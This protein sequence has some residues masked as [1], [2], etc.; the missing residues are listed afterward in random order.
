MTYGSSNSFKNDDMSNLSDAEIPGSLPPAQRQ[1]KPDDLAG[2]EISPSGL[3]LHFPQLD[4][5][6]YLPSLLEGFLGSRQWMASEMGKSEGQG[7][8]VAKAAAARDNGKLGERPKKIREPEPFES[9]NAVAAAT[10][11][12]QTSPNTPKPM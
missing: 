1:P 3:G 2:I 9:G 11:I 12:G 5:D 6:V 10:S 8:T 7:A 4:A